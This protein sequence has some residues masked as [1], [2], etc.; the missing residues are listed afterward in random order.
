MA[1]EEAGLRYAT[2]RGRWVIAATVLGS[3]IASLDATVVGI[4][5]PRIG[6]SFHTGVSSVQWV[7]TGYTL[8]LAAFLLLGG[9]LG[10]RFG[11]RRVFTI[12]VAWFAVASA[13][14]AAA[15][16][17]TALIA[18][19]LVQ[20]VG[21]ALL[22]PGSLAILE[23][24]FVREDRGR[25]I[26]AWS[27]LGGLAA[28]AGPLLGGYLITAASWRWVFVINLPLGAVVT[29][30][31]VRH[32][33]ESRDPQA[34]QR[35]DGM[36]AVFAVVTLGGLSYALIE[37]P[38]AGWSSPIVVGGAVAAVVGSAAFLL[39]E[40]R[41]KAPM[42]PMGIFRE[43][44]F[45][46]ANGVTFVVYAALA[47]ALFLL[48]VELQVA[49]GYSPTRAGLALLPVTVIMLVFSAR[50]GRLAARIGPRL[51]MSA[52]PVVVGAGLA[53][54]IRVTDGAGYVQYVLPG[55][56]VFGAGLAIT[57]AP[58]T[59]TAMEAAPSEHAGLASAV[60]NDVAR[61]AGL[62]AV[63][64]LPIAAGITGASYLHPRELSDGFRSAALMAAGLCVA[65]GA[66][67]AATIRNPPAA[68]AASEC[69]HCALDAPQLLPG[70]S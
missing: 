43:R 24:S 36:G 15:P 21:A 54:L 4:A 63:A 7:V 23:A 61:A 50:S 1:S 45:S 42:L 13:G 18:A 46:A 17:A 69:F 25:A 60:N 14:C 68:P 64:V 2:G 11:R 55:V 53:L 5:V 19:R 37:G 59:S 65:G 39:V 66:L 70:Q 49:A 33:P 47:G 57:V 27:G 9:S 40:R 67:A 35:T 16:T 31:A 12:G 3:G 51:Q 28:A 26:G 10:D 20:G 32:V 56:V 29:A 48:P 62:I 6:R 8:T 52:G 22:T 41:G 30:I 34:P 58:L 44:Q 38:V